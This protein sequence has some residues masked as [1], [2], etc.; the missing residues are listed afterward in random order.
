MAQVRAALHEHRAG[1]Y[2]CQ[3]NIFRETIYGAG[4]SI[5]C[6]PACQYSALKRAQAGTRAPE[7]A[8][9]SPHPFRPPPYRAGTE[10]F[11]VMERM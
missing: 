3:Y 1:I 5:Y 10:T 2:I 6:T 7:G 8:I 9:F 4:D 11:I